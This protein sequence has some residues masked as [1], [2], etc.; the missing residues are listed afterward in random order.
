MPENEDTNWAEYLLSREWRRQYRED[1]GDPGP[2]DLEIEEEERKER[3]RFE[4]TLNNNARN[5]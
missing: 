1:H 5:K 4:P 3:M 2:D